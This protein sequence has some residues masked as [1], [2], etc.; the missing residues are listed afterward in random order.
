M[1]VKR[2]DQQSTWFAKDN[3][4]GTRH[5][6]V[7]L[8]PQS[9]PILFFTNERGVDPI[10]GHHKQ[11]MVVNDEAAHGANEIHVVDLST[12]KDWKIDGALLIAYL[13]VFDKRDTRPILPYAAGLSPDDK[14]V[15]I[16]MTLGCGN[17]TDP[18]EPSRDYVVDL[19]SGKILKEYKTDKIPDHWWIDQN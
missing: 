15:L 7:Q 2:F 8:T 12:G 9:K 10:L 3:L 17:G 11:Y 16:Q 1:F 18:D 5:F 13:S 19:K 4:E 14:Q 6:Y